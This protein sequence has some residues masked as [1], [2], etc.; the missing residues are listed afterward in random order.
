MANGFIDRRENLQELVKFAKQHQ[1]EQLTI[2]PINRPTSS[3]NQEVYDWTAQHY[4]QPGQ[5]A[6][7][8]DFLEHQGH[9]LMT[10]AHGAQ[11]YDLDG[12]NVCLTDSLTIQATSD[13]LR[14]LIF[15]PDGHLRYDWQYSGAILL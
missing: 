1:V 3:R 5:L 15:F 12:Q 14:Q 10:L 11:V 8:R 2:R 4:L 6:D 7:I 9:L 13:S